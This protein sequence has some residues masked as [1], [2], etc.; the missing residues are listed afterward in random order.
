MKVYVLRTEEWEKWESPRHE[1]VGVYASKKL[2]LEAGHKIVLDLLGPDCEITTIGRE[3]TYS[4]HPLN[5]M[6]EVIPF[7]LNEF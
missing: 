5:I 6:I 3:T 7:T 2:A 1:I 4:K